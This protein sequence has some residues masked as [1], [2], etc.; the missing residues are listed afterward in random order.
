MSITGAKRMDPAAIRTCL[1]TRQRDRFTFAI[2]GHADPVCGQP[3]FDDAA[4][5]AELWAWPWT[6][7]P[8]LD[9][10]ILERDQ[11]RIERWYR[12]RG[13]YDAVVK[14]ATVTDLGDR[15]VAVR[16]E[17]DEG[18]PVLIREV[19]IA[20]ATGDTELSEQ[21]QRAH[22][23]VVGEPFDE[24]LYDEAK[25]AL[26]KALGEGGYAHSVVEGRVRL[27]PANRTASIRYDVRPGRPARFGRVFVR[28]HGDL[29]AEVIWAAAGIR[30]GAPFSISA[31]D[32][33][34]QAVYALGPFASVEVA[35]L[36]EPEEDTVHV[37]VRVV[38]GQ[39][40]RFR[41]GAGLQSGGNISTQQTDGSFAQW[42]IHL[43]A[44]F[45]HRNFLGG[46]R[47]LQIEER[48]RLIFDGRFP[49]TDA[50]NLGNA[51]RIDFRQPAFLEAR[52]SLL[53]D[54]RWDLGPDPFGGRFFRSDLNL[55]V[56]PERHFFRG[57]LRIKSTIN[58]HQFRE[59]PGI[60]QDLTGA[61]DGPYPDYDVFFMNHVAQL[62]L[63]DNPRAPTRGFY[64]QLGVIHAGFFLPGDFDYIRFIPDLRGYLPLP[65]GLVLAA[66][67]RLGIM[68]VSGANVGADSP[69]TLGELTEQGFVQRLARFGPLRHRL[70]GGGHNSVRGYRPNELGDAVLVDG[71]LD[72][73][74]LRQWEGSI[75]LRL[76]VTQNLGAVLF[77]DAG[78]V[79]RNARFR[80]NHPQT[81]LGFGLRYRTLVGPLRLDLGFAPSGLQVI[82]RDER[83]RAGLT[84]AKVFGLAP[85]AVHLTIGEAF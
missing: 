16:V 72:S 68:H 31:L 6:E 8:L 28:G 65:G 66:R 40:T 15:R 14:D 7:W 34:R 37:L 24:F 2:G 19:D 26:Q 69:T 23:L 60:F 63:R 30:P 83:V 59:L 3:P 17:V 20:V 64:A 12:A 74:G 36:V 43:L 27:D 52:T 76:P 58:W 5:R 13:Y 9:P 33:A 29:P 78:D 4:M 84:Q 42:D 62:D 48:P 21:L 25:Q 61:Q 41:V 85:G 51:L 73:G 18:E 53:A 54:L 49:E 39:E 56:G 80:F 77:A 38:R 44:R 22:S 81:T 67:G 71:R 1:A 50:P 55:G 70:R 82:G 32:D 45:E 79:S 35:P 75:E 46:M 57:A 47:R 10:A 11:E